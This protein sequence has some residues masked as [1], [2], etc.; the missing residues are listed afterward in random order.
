MNGEVRGEGG[1]SPAER[2]WEE[3]YRASTRPSNGR[4]SGALVRFAGPLPRGTALDLGCSQGDDAIWLAQRGWRV[5]AV[6]VSGTVLAR[7]A[8][9]AQTAGVSDL[10]AFERHDL[11]STFPDGRFDLVCALF[12][13]S[14]VEFP[15]TRV[16]R[17]AGLGP[18]RPAADGRARLGRAVVV[19]RPGHGLPDPR[20]ITGRARPGPFPVAQRI[21]GRPRTSGHRPERAVRHRHRQRHRAQ[22]TRAMTTVCPP[23][24]VST[25]TGRVS[26]MSTDVSA[27]CHCGSVRLEVDTPPSEVTE[28]NCS[29]CRRYGVLWA[30][31]PPYQVRMLPPIRPPTSTSGVA[32]PSS[33][34][35]AGTAAASRIGPLWTASATGWALTRASC[36]RRSWPAPA[37]ATA[38]APTPIGTPTDHRWLR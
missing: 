23:K 2:F 33:S 31:Y 21:R 15:R 37:Y 28:C 29:I 6:D 4:P 18:P 10:I 11:A 32:G 17:A 13:H 5:V 25:S 8:K 26:V 9:N 20:A 36:P 12:L 7:A 14:P 38:M 35:A 16:L 1:G 19:G 30:Y 24:A 3:H 34:T 27:S 22:T